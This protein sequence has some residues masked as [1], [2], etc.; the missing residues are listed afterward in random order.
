MNEWHFP[1]LHLQASK[2]TNPM[3]RCTV[4]ENSL[5]ITKMILKNIYE[6]HGTYA[7]LNGKEILK[8]GIFG[9]LKG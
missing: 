8:N 3:I 4:G 5:E 2:Q 1:R 6:K 9:I 7:F